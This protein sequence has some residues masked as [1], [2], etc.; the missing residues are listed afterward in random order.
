MNCWTAKLSGG[1]QHVH[2][3]GMEE[4]DTVPHGPLRILN[5]SGLSWVRR[6]EKTQLWCDWRAFY[7][8][9]RNHTLRTTNYWQANFDMIGQLWSAGSMSFEL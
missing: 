1:P 6:A 4:N 3:Q 5:K 2:T 8:P 7:A 9:L